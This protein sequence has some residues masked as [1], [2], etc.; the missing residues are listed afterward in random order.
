MEHWRRPVRRNLCICICLWLA[1]WSW[2]SPCPIWC[3][4]PLPYNDS[5]GFHAADT[6]FHLLGQAGLVLCAP[7]DLSVQWGRESREKKS[8]EKGWSRKE[9][10]TRGCDRAS[11][12]ADSRPGREAAR[13]SG[14]ATFKCHE[15]RMSRYSGRSGSLQ[16]GLLYPRPKS[17][18]CKVK[19]FPSVFRVPM[20][21]PW[22]KSYDKPRQRIKKQRCSCVRVGP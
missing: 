14:P 20:L 16:T 11:G 4:G 9:I 18:K 21:A 15:N 6:Q 17:P 13:G 19:S 12:R 2:A 10:W 8:S 22:N 1:V 3:Q 7:W 5:P